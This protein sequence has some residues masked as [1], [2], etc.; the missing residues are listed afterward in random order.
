MQGVRRHFAQ[1]RMSHGPRHPRI[2][3]FT[4]SVD[5][6]RC[7]DKQCPAEGQLGG[8]PRPRITPMVWSHPRYSLF[9]DMSLT[10]YRYYPGASAY[11][12][13]VEPGNI[14]GKTIK[15]DPCL[16]STSSSLRQSNHILK[17]IPLAD[18]SPSDLLP[19]P[20]LR[21]RLQHP[22]AVS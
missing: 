17:S 6:V 13:V 14:R 16:T 5:A 18:V 1:R 4:S 15:L 2:Y 11:D 8:S 10:D 3:H 19:H 22:I 21:K 20:P 12:S 9:S 7:H